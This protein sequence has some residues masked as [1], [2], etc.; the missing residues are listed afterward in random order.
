LIESSPRNT[1]SRDLYG[2]FVMNGV[3]PFDL[4]GKTAIVTGGGQG[5][6]EATVKFLV[7]L[8]ANVIVNDIAD[9]KL[10][11]LKNTNDTIAVSG[12]VTNEN[13]V[14]NVVSKAIESFG[15]ID[16]L[17]NN[18][19]TVQDSQV[20]DMSVEG[21]DK[22]I[23]VNLKGAFLMSKHVLPHMIKENQGK[24]INI[25]ST[26]GLMGSVGRA[27]YA[28]AKMGMVGFGT[29]LAL[30]VERH[31]INVNCVAPFAWTRLTESM[32]NIDELSHEE[33]NELRS[34]KPEY[35]A[36]FIG[37]LASPAANSINGQIFCIRG[38]EVIL[39]SQSRPLCSIHSHSGWDFETFCSTIVE[40]FKD[41]FVELRASSSYFS[42]K[43]LV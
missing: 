30:E 26:A 33:V 36:R 15:R 37:F 21:F 29:S 5:I 25:V 9:D 23:D 2:G 31:H 8:G 28:A 3:S 43:P 38:Q 22:V 19:G 42:Y 14:K 12:S 40:R 35:V 20:K 16:I 41:E 4:D 24:I 6:G 10:K 1:I 7:E 11:D 39:F 34:L 13:D 17:V 32:P 27:N 18:A